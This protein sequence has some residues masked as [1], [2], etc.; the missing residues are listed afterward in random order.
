MTVGLHIHSVPL[1]QQIPGSV[2]TVLKGIG[3][4][5]QHTSKPQ[6]IDAVHRAAARAGLN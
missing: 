5:P 4:M 3:H 1:S 2:L 6:V